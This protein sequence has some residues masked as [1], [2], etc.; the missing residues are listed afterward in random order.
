MRDCAQAS[1]TVSGWTQQAIRGLQLGA[2]RG[3]IHIRGQFIWSSVAGA[4]TQALELDCAGDMTGEHMVAMANSLNR[5]PQMGRC[6][7][8]GRAVGTPSRIAGAALVR[9]CRGTSFGT[10]VWLCLE[11]TTA[12]RQLDNQFP[13]RVLRHRNGDRIK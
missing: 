8:R 2:R 1:E 9:A 7:T 5:D 12:D 10:S 3:K 13:A 4:A 11:E 6:F